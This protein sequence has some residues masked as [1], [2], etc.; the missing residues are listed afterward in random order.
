[1][2]R[3]KGAG[4]IFRMSVRDA[5]IGQVLLRNVGARFV[6]TIEA[7]RG[8]ALPNALP[9]FTWDTPWRICRLTECA[10]Y[11]GD[12]MDGFLGTRASV[13]LDVVVLAMFVVLPVM[14][15]SIYQVKY[16]RRY[17]LHKRV[18]VVLAAV[19]LVTV[20]AFEIDIQFFANWE[21]RA[22]ASPYFYTLVTP[23][24]WIHLFFAVPTAVIWIYHRVACDC[25]TS[26]IRRGRARRARGIF[27]GGGWRR[28]R[29]RGRRSRDGFFIIWRL[30][31]EVSPRRHGGHGEAIINRGG[32]EMQRKGWWAGGRLRRPIPPYRL[33]HPAKKRPIPS[34]ALLEDI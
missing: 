1:M 24:L 9:S 25:G 21:E 34:A 5:E 7:R 14:C 16:R 19:L 11:C 4:L 27:F 8:L 10:N 20:A 32:T 3:I 22:E 26:P 2:P 30:W 33:Q 13:M 17:E 18:Q 31:R 6:S 12:G 23:A 29:W 28:G 15:W